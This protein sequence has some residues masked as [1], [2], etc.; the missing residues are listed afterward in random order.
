MLH[1]EIYTMSAFKVSRKQSQLTLQSTYHILTREERLCN[2]EMTA[3][4]RVLSLACGQYS[5]F[6]ALLLVMIETRQER[7]ERVKM[8]RQRAFEHLLSSRAAEQDV[9]TS[10]KGSD[11]YER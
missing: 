4:E 10:M 3:S 2:E 6:T 1:N 9:I 7:L 8:Y 5:T 11:M